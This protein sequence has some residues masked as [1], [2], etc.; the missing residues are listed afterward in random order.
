VRP[1]VEPGPPLSPS[2]TVRFS[3]HALLPQLGEQGQ[4]RLRNAAVC[5]VGAGGLGSPALLY[6]AAAGV[7]RL[8]VVDR[9]V[10]DLTNL[11]RQ[12]LHG[13]GDVGRAKV[14]SARDALQRI[15]PD[16]VIDVHDVDLTAANA[17]EVLRGYD[18]VLDG[19]DNF[20]TRYLVG[21]ACT[22]LGVPLV[23]G[24]V[25]GFDAQVSVFW[26]TPPEGEGV[27]LRDLF[28][29]PPEP[30]EVLSCAQAGVLGALCGQVGAVMATEAVKLLT[31]VG[32][33]LLGRVLVIDSLAG[34]WRE[35]PLRPAPRATAR[36][37]PG[38]RAPLN[39]P[40]ARRADDRLPDATGEAAQR[41]QQRV[42][43]TIEATDLAQL[44]EGAAPPALVDVREPHEHA[45]GAI[46]GSMLVPLSEL[47][48]GGGVEAV[49]DGPV[50][51]YCSSGIRSAQAVR[52]LRASGRRDVL[53]LTGGIA[54][55]WASNGGEGA[56][57][58]RDASP[59][60]S[61]PV[62]VAAP[63]PPSSDE[64]AGGRARLAL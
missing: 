53:H 64:P 51:L 55:W 29:D 45:A 32:E 49:P 11:Q 63:S 27:V 34:R 59:A 28:P 4:R 6:L 21:D 8:G 3:R 26:S 16:L 7:G 20:P 39:Q 36:R 35:V 60:A 17:E 24:S 50:V 10:V 15:D 13:A 12:V 40:V 47:L 18:V 9:D 52:L 54:A 30:G 31:G 33:P 19:T 43:A 58:P 2:E 23:W 48:A 61:R 44:L 62:A 42:A 14:E 38:E 46:P 22:A 56:P 25:L 57:M 1:L 5:V 37:P 41:S